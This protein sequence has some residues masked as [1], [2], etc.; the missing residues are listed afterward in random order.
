MIYILIVDFVDESE[1][2]SRF[3]F[4]IKKLCSLTV[5]WLTSP[6]TIDQTILT[7]LLCQIQHI[8]RLYLSGYIFN[9]NLDD[10]VNLKA[11]SLTT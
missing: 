4:S 3:D 11:L 6:Y 2:Y 8:E 5:L 7:E 10:L 9:F 1:I